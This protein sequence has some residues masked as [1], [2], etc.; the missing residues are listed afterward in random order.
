MLIM[1]EE[2]INL[3]VMF[4]AEVRCIRFCVLNS[5]AFVLFFRSWDLAW[6]RLRFI[7]AKVDD[8]MLIREE[9]DDK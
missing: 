5:L 4:I 3:F 6:R 7:L 1:V 9:S 8:S 2:L